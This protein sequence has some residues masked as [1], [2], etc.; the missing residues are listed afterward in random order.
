MYALQG[1]PDMLTAK[2]VQFAEK[3]RAQPSLL[4]G[5]GY[6]AGRVPICAEQT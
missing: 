4:L 5:I 6:T 3:R 1:N 2:R